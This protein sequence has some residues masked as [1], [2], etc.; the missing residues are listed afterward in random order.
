MHPDPMP[1]DYDTRRAIV[2][3]RIKTHPAASLTDLSERTGYSVPYIS[4][5]LRG[6]AGKRSEPVIRAAESYMDRL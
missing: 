3:D 5:V 1:K 2:R 6:A 4:D